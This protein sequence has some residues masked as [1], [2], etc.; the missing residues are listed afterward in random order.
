MKNEFGFVIWP[1]ESGN[2]KDSGEGGMECWLCVPY[3]ND[4]THGVRDVCITGVILSF[5]SWDA[6]PGT[7]EISRDM[8]EMDTLPV[9]DKREA[10]DRNDWPFLGAAICVGATKKS[11]FYVNGDVWTP[12]VADLT[13]EGKT[14]YHLVANLYDTEPVFVMALDT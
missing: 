13:P 5:V 14:I 9:F 7:D 2:I 12:T 8:S 6:M 1:E 4:N 11:L 3:F 10:V